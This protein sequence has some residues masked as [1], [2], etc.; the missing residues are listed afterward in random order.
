MKDRQV[1][2]RMSKTRDVPMQLM[3][4]AEATAGAAGRER[5]VPAQEFGAK[6]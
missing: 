6:E 5:K 3:F 1:K 2:Q 4:T